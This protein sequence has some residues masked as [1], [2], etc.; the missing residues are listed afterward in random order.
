MAD[1]MTDSMADDFEI[2]P[3]GQEM[4]SSIGEKDQF[5]TAEKS[6][7]L[8]L[9]AYSLQCNSVINKQKLEMELLRKKNEDKKPNGENCNPS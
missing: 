4:T 8:E 5:E 6:N 2:I 1:S 3:E 7:I 9:D